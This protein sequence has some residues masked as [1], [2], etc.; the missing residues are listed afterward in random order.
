MN[1]YKIVIRSETDKYYDSIYQI[2]SKA[3]NHVNEAK[4]I[5][6]LRKTPD[7][8]PELSLIASINN[9]PIGH[10]LFYPLNIET[11][12]GSIATL[13]LV[14]LAVKPE[15]QKQGIGSKLVEKGLKIA[16]ELGFKSIFVV[17]DPEFYGRFGFK[18]VNGI[19]NNIGEPPDHFM[20]IELEK[21]SLANVKGALIYLEVFKEL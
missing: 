17:G 18:L 20:Y 10:V 9:E 4:L 2:H 5:N 14:P 11:E 12:N 7:Y 15:F 16:G 21:D 3:F 19:S 8:K 6:S 13:G 1:N